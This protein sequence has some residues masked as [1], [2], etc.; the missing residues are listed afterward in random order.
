MD[1]GKEIGKHMLVSHSSLY[2]KEDEKIAHIDILIHSL[3]DPDPFSAY[4]A[5]EAL[6]DYINIGDANCIVDVLHQRQIRVD[7]TSNT[8]ILELLHVLLKHIRK[9]W[10]R[11]SSVDTNYVINLL[12]LFPVFN[13][14]TTD[15]FNDVASSS[16]RSLFLSTA[17]FALYRGSNLRWCH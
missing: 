9:Q 15:H 8:H 12:K 3:E 13:E 11:G 10:K 5:S 7:E 4:Q 16:V 17:A 2:N 6:H 1:K 14:Q